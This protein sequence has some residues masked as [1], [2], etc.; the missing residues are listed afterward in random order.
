MLQKIPTMN[1]TN[2]MMMYIYLIDSFKII[3]ID[4]INIE[5]FILQL[6]MVR[7]SQSINI[8]T[9]KKIRG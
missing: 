4:C 8:N 1:V 9:Y 3:V 5:Q 2:S 7:S 6:V